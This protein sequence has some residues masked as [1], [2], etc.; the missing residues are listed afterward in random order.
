M[1]LLRVII[2]AVLVAAVS[3]GTGFAVNF[4]RRQG[5][6]PLVR[7]KPQAMWIDVAAAKQ[8]WDRGTTIFLDA[9]L[10]VEY[11]AGHMPGA[12]SLPVHDIETEYEHVLEDIDITRPIIAYC[13]GIGCESS[14]ELADAL[15]GDYR[16]HDVRVLVEPGFDDWTAE[17]YPVA[18]GGA[19]GGASATRQQTA[20][21]FTATVV[22]ILLMALSVLLA[23]AALLTRGSA[24]VWIV[25]LA[26]VFV[27]AVLIW[28]AYPKILEPNE[29]AKGVI[30]YQAIPYSWSNLPAIAL[31]WLEMVAGVLLVIGAVTRGSALV[32]SVLYLAF[33]AMMISAMTRGVVIDDCACF[34]F[35][36]PLTWLLVWRDVALLAAALVPLFAGAGRLAIDSLSQARLAQ[37]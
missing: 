16:H 18:T 34:G 23:L 2:S 7:A 25:T 10:P 11:E 35:A 3:V 32:A 5:S 30:A 9:R 4:A 8:E 21:V 36:E 27:G 19:A 26:R 12:L 20:S 33:L 6:L 13:S 37:A 22:P 24:R 28:A 14:V 17:R 29:F 31:P 15:T 1:K